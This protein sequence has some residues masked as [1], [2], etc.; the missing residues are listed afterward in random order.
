VP[1]HAKAHV[2]GDAAE[3]GEFGAVEG[4]AAFQQRIDAGGAGEGAERGAVL[5]RRGVDEIR[6]AQAAGAGHVLRHDGRIAGDVLAHVAGEMAGVEVVAAADGK[7][8]RQIDGLALVELLD[9]L[10]A[11]GQGG[12]SDEGEGGGQQAHFK[13]QTHRRSRRASNLIRWARALSIN[14]ARFGERSAQLNVCCCVL[15]AAA[16]DQLVVFLVHPILQQIEI[17]FRNRADVGGHG[18][19]VPHRS[20]WH[21]TA[22]VARHLGTALI[23][24]WKSAVGGALVRDRAPALRDRVVGHTDRPGGQN[25]SGESGAHEWPRVAMVEVQYAMRETQYTASLALGHP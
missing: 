20:L 2:V 17:V 5:R 6:R 18:L 11:D 14:P 10:G 3:P 13:L 8:D 22:A 21:A 4:R 9:A 1:G 7:A 15:T 24:C 12:Q 23:D 25:E 16:Q 19:A